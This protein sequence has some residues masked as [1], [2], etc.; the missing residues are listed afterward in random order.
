MYGHFLLAILLLGTIQTSDGAPV[1]F[2]MPRD[3]DHIFEPTNRSTSQCQQSELQMILIE[4][5]FNFRDNFYAIRNAFQPQ[6]GVHK[7]CIPVSYVVTCID[8]SNQDSIINCAA[9]YQQSMIWT[10]F[11]TTDTAGNIVFELAS[12][13]FSVF[14]FDWAGACVTELTSG[15]ILYLEL[16]TTSLPCN[17][18]DQMDLLQTLRYITTMVSRISNIIIY[19]N[20]PHPQ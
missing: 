11:D 6:P 14:G 9:G 15:T 4:A 17:G 5:I 7:I 18:T 20:L 8:Q 10:E 1:G 13:G 19:E 3:I 16:N 2:R 12:S